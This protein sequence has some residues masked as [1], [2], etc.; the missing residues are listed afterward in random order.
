MEYQDWLARQ[1]EERR[2]H[3]RGVAYRMLG[4]G[5]EADDAVQEA[6]MRAQ[7]AG[8]SDVANLGGWLTTIVSRV[9]LDMLRSRVSRREDSIDAPETQAPQPVEQMDPESEAVLADSVGMAMMVVLDTLAPAERVAFVLHDLFDVPFDQIAAIV[10]RS[11]PATRQ[12]ASRARRRVRGQEPPTAQA[13]RRDEIVRAFLAASREGRFDELL[14]VLDP[15]VVVRADT[16]VAAIGAPAAVSGAE[17]VAKVFSGWR[18]LA[19]QPA[20]LGGAP[21]LVWI[22]HNEVRVAFAFSFEGDR[23]AAIDLIGDA[24]HVQR[25]AIELH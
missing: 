19:A 21:G 24:A 3:L 17:N 20:L 9:C 8:T 2:A 16:A 4:S 1:F 12:L 11:E 7:R 5:A 18:M 10:G 6:W 13:S 25:L 14:K 15:S 23:I 22:E